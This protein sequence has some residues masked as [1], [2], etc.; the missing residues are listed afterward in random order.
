MKTPY[1]QNGLRKYDHLPPEEAIIRAWMTPGVN[2]RWHDLTRDAVRD[3]MPVMAR[4]LDR[5]E[6]E[7][8]NG[9][10]S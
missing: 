9:H 1:T 2:P 5:L 7:Y 8:K 10:T 6:K 3:A 4:A